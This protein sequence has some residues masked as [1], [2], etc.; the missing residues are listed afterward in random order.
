MSQQQILQQSER[1]K[2][3]LSSY[4]IAGIL[5]RLLFQSIEPLARSSNIL[6]YWIS[7]LLPLIISDSRRKSHD[8]LEIS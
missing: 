5:D 8:Y 1:I 7:E 4:Q 6:G 3:N 2:E